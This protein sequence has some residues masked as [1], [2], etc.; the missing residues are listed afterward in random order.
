LF[1]F[2]ATVCNCFQWLYFWRAFVGALLLLQ[3]RRVHQSHVDAAAE[4]ELRLSS[5]RRAG[6]NLIKPSFCVTDASENKLEFLPIE[7]IPPY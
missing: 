3:P 6:F 4:G 2:E 5:G 1:I 7:K